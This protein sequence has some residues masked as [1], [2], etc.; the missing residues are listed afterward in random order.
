MSELGYGAEYRYAHDEPGAYAAGEEYFP[1][2]LAGKHY[3]QPTE[4]G[5]RE[6]NRPEARL[7][8]RAGPAEPASKRQVKARCPGSMAIPRIGEDKPAD[9]VKL[10][11]ND[12]N[13]PC[14]GGGRS[15]TLPL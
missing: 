15:A 4:S 7:P 3:Y 2:E 5:P 14:S 10:G 1:P 6:A 11:K 13:T 12:S 9:A 8:A